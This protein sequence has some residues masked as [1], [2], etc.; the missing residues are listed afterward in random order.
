M[1]TCV[2]VATHVCIVSDVLWAE[3]YW[4]MSRELVMLLFAE[5]NSF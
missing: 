5:L 3:N 2:F 4:E 1:I